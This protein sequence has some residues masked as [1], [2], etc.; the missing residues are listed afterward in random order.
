MRLTYPV[1]E[2]FSTLQ[3]EGRWSGHRAV[4]VRF[5]GCN[6]WSGREQD[7]ERDTAKGCCAAWCDT[8]FVGTNGQH[9][10]MH[11]AEQIARVV[12]SLG[13]RHV[14]LTGGEPSLVVDAKLVE[15][16]H[17]V[18]AF[19]Q[20]ETNGSRPV[21]PS[22]DWVTLSPKPPMTVLEQRYDEVKCVFPAGFDLL[23]YA[24]FADVRYVQPLDAG[25]KATNAQQ[26]LDFVLAHEGWALSL[27]THKLLDIP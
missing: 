10:G 12:Q 16:L 26:A 18:G 19:V 17:G 1:K 27:Q 2:V 23:D 14:V 20:I 7:R 11:T 5:A 4:F 3:G 25:D 8:D 22:I 13:G 6:V 15:A 9:G 21:S 24:R